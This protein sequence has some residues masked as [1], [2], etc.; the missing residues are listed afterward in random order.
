MHHNELIMF[1][2]I[3]SIL[4][5]LGFAVKIFRGEAA[6]NRKMNKLIAERNMRNRNRH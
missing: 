6:H 1:C 5:V 3:V 2:F 4:V